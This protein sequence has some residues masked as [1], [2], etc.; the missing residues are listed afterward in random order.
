MFNTQEKVIEYCQKNHCRIYDIVLDHDSENTRT[1]KEQIILKLSSMIDVMEESSRKTLEEPRSTNTGMIDGFA[2]RM[3]LYSKEEPVSGPFMAQLMAMAFSTL[4]TSASMGRIVASPTAGASG[5]L[6]AV[7]MMMKEE[8][9]FKKDELTNALL[10]SIG[11][12]QIIGKYANFSGAEGGCQAETGSAASMG[13]AAI[14]ELRNGTVEQ[15]FHAAS[16]ALINILGLVCDPIAGLVEYP[17]TFRNANGAVNAVISADMALAGVKSIVP[18]EEVTQAMNDV[19]KMLPT[20]LRETGIG[21]LA[22]TKTGRRIRSK[23]L[24]E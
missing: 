7:L 2:H 23:F 16:I 3:F 13:A 19:G 8:Y 12:G 22:G 18:F 20:A 10:T 21:G 6:P 24:N 14:V 4:E 15:C 9:G 17:C 1:S 5:I 11:I